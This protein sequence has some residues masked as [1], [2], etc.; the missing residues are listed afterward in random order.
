MFSQNGVGKTTTTTIERTR[1][2]PQNSISCLTGDSDI[3]SPNISSMP[4]LHHK[5]APPNHVSFLSLRRTS[6]GYGVR[7]LLPQMQT[8]RTYCAGLPVGRTPVLWRRPGTPSSQQGEVLQ[9]Q[10]VWPLC[11][12]VQ[13]GGRSLLPLQG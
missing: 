2:A 12:R 1:N 6:W 13:G 7:T 11:A 8:S 3:F 9:M 5:P 4:R 10:P